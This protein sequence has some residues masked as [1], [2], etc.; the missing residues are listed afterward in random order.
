[1]GV[2]RILAFAREAGGA[3]AIA[4]VLV[5][6]RKHAQL[7]VLAKDHA[8]KVFRDAGV[9]PVP[10]PKFSDASLQ[11]ILET[12]LG[13]E[14]PDVVFT[15]ATS[16][17]QLDMTEKYLWE[18][19]RARRVRSVAVLDQWQNYA[20]RFSGPGPGERLRYLPDLVA[21]MDE[22]AKEGMIAAGIPGERIVVTGQPA[23]DKLARIRELYAPEDS[24]LLRRTIGVAPDARLICFVAEAFQR[25]FGEQLGYTEQSVLREL[26]Q[27][28]GRVH[29]ESKLPLHLAVKLHP[30]NDPGEFAWLQKYPATPGLQVTLHWT[31]QPPIPLVMASDVVVGMTSVLLVESILLGRP[32][33]SF[34]PGAREREG[35]I[36]TVIGAIPLLEDRDACFDVL[37]GLLQD[38]EFRSRYLARQSR[39]GADGEATVRVAELVRNARLSQEAAASTARPARWAI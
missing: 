21:V 27:V 11:E 12:R 13:G 8:E 38:P 37:R 1:M 10:L 5:E 23:F 24:E 36:A 2:P 9:V 14:L 22:H 30:R 39:L 20:L 18:W 4:P 33:V 17:P 28:C 35:L 29:S 3:A 25:D 6:L 15:S 19:A 31:E 34:Q 26:I 7:L 16:L 32:T